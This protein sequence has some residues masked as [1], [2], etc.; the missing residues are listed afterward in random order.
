MGASGGAMKKLFDKELLKCW[1]FTGIMS[2]ETFHLYP[3]LEESYKRWL[4]LFFWASLAAILFCDDDDDN[5][6]KRKKKPR[7]TPEWIKSL[8]HKKMEALAPC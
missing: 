2:F 5:K 6:K 1:V 4:V 7:A 8:T 3:S